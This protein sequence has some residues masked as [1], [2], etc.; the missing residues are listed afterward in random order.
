MRHFSLQQCTLHSSIVYICCEKVF[1]LKASD[2]AL[3]KSRKLT[4]DVHFDYIVVQTCILKQREI[5]IRGPLD[6]QNSQAG[7]CLGQIGQ[8]YGKEI[9]D[10]DKQFFICHARNKTPAT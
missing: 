8:Y 2:L 1:R 4:R 6:C 7:L 9:K 3:N 5:T 10:S